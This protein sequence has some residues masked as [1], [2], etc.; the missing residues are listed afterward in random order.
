MTANQYFIKFAAAMKPINLSRSVE[1]GFFGEM[2]SLGIPE[3]VI[4]ILNRQAVFFFNGSKHSIKFFSQRFQRCLKVLHKTVPPRT[5]KSTAIFS[6]SMSSFSVVVEFD[7]ESTALCS[8]DFTSDPF[9]LRDM[10]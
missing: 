8:T 10:V 4:R 3:V 5:S 7:T 1:M 2:Q 6:A 9:T